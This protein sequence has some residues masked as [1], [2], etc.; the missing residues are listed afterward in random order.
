[1]NVPQRNAV[2]EQPRSLEVAS[3]SVHYLLLIC[4]TLHIIDLLFYAIGIEIG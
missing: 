2:H 3:A 4:Y 1:M